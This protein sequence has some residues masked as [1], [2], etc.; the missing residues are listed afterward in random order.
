M[1]VVPSPLPP[2]LPPPPPGLALA[3]SLPGKK[4]LYQAIAEG[5]TAVKGDFEEACLL[6]TQ[7]E[8]K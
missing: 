4:K 1:S 3:P 2:P 7:R 5:R 6:L 8:S